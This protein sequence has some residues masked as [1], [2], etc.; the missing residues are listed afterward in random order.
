MDV[1]LGNITYSIRNAKLEDAEELCNIEDMCFKNEDSGF[2]KYDLKFFRSW[3]AYNPDM[4]YLAETD[5]GNGQTVIVGFVIFVPLRERAFKKMECGETLDM[6]DFT[7]DDVYG[8][9][10]SNEVLPIDLYYFSDIAVRNDI[11]E[12][13]ATRSLIGFAIMYCL[14][15]MMLAGANKVLTYPVTKEGASLTGLFGGVLASAP[16]QRVRSRD[17]IE[18]M[19]LIDTSNPEVREKIEKCAKRL[20]PSVAKKVI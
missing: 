13:V 11:P 19:C 10:Q 5:L 15:D 18:Q 7:V 8:Q 3:L 16:S 6:H 9:S 12:I 4:F 17:M 20:E 1:T 14:K 2:K